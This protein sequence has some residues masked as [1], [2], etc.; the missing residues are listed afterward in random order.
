MSTKNI[1]NSKGISETTAKATNGL[2]Y[3]QA[4]FNQLTTASEGLSF[5]EISDLIKAHN[6]T[7]NNIR[8]FIVD[9]NL[10]DN[11]A[12]IGGLAIDKNA[13]YKMAVISNI[14][15]ILSILTDIDRE[16]YNIGNALPFYTESNGTISVNTDAITTAFTR[17]LTGDQFTYYTAVKTIV[18]ALVSFN[19]TYGRSGLWLFEQHV[20]ITNFGKNIRLKEETF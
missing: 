4:L 18:D 8:K 2:P 1:V 11:S 7:E 14:D 5:S 15:T 10:G 12:T 20:D 19:S 17:T 3:V 16:W 6:F 13:L 9:K